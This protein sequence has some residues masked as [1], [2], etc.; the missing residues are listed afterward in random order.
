MNIVITLTRPSIIACRVIPDH[1]NETG[2][3]IKN[4]FSAA[5]MASIAW[6]IIE[7][8]IHRNATAHF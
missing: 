7:V 6:R 1:L 5:E 8:P 4:A 3:T 2:A